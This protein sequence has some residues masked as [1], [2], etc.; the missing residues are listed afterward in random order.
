MKPNIV[1]IEVDQMRADCLG[2]NDPT[3][4]VSTPVLD[5][6]ARAG[7]NFGQ[8][9]SVTPSCVPARAGLL[10]G[11]NPAHTGRVGYEDLMPWHFAQTLPQSFRD[12]GYQTEAIGKMHVYPPRKRLGYD[13][14]VL[15][16]GYLHVERKHQQPYVGNFEN[17]DDYLADLRRQGD[18][19]YTDDGLN[20]NA[21]DARPWP[22]PEDQHPTNW[23]VKQGIDFL[24]RRDPTCPFFLKLS[25]D[26]PH[27]PL[28][29]PPYYFDM[30]MQ[31][32]KDHRLDLHMGDWEQVPDQPPALEAM[33]GK[34]RDDDERRM[35]A[36]YLGL[37]SQLDHQIGRFLTALVE[38]GEFDHT[39]IWFVSDHG[40]LLGEHGFFRKMLPYQGSIH[41]PSFLYDPGHLLAG[42]PHQIDA[43]VVLQDLFASLVD[44]TGGEPVATD[45]Q[46]VRPLIEGKAPDSADS[47]LVFGEHAYWEWSAQFVLQAGIKL[48]WFPCQDR[49]QLFDLTRDPN[50]RHDAIGDPAYAGAVAALKAALTKHLANR[51]EGFVQNGQLTRRTAAQCQPTLAFVRRQKEAEHD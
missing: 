5:D 37:I 26:K 31:R 36:G 21:W 24:K 40:D 27:A 33:Q 3:G 29:P 16:D 13:H 41:V 4:F 7:Y 48:V 44:L 15:H 2:I 6:M 25:F 20:C 11:L 14:V 23:I 1:L 47:R 8:M 9:Y 46:S 43:P 50:E 51:E 30:Y 10:T 18:R 42:T 39:L 22:Y 17:S 32:L 35:V 12:R 49:Y 45:G 19:D 34:L 38:T 28:D